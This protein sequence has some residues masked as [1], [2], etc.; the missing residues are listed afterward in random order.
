[1]LTPKERI[2]CVFHRETPDRVPLGAY[3]C[4][5]PR[6]TTEREVR[7]KGCGLVH[8]ES[9]YTK[10][11]KNVEIG[12]KE[13][14]KNSE[15]IVTRIYRTPVG[16]IYEEI[17]LDPGYHSQWTKEFVIK[18]PSDYRVAKYIVEN[19]VYHKNYDFFLEVQENLG[20]DGILIAN[21]DRTPFQRTLIELVGTHRLCM[22]LYDR[23]SVVKDFFDSLRRK[24]DE[25]YQIAADSPAEIIH[26]W[27]NLTEDITEPKLFQKYCLPLYNKYGRML[28][29]RGKIYAVHMDGKLKHLKNLIE[30]AEIDVIESF[31]LP[32]AGGNLPVR[33]AQSAWKDKTIVVNLPAFLCF[34]NK[35]FVKKFIRDLLNQLAKD[36]FMLNVSENLPQ[37]SW[38][39]TLTVVAD[40]MQAYG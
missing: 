25:I 23:P 7:E 22:D 40:A 18:K 1:M 34:K 24:Q 4:F 20:E 6:G 11:I 33:E 17:K 27:D 15:K 19:T 31:T 37:K 36:R 29:E 12:I 9:V 32:G 39:Q 21:L 2:R 13:R 26:N 3:F 30:K 35:D 28:H 10:E 14:W 38:K 5:L 8:F 16:S